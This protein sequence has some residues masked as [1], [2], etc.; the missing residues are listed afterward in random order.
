MFRNDKEEFKKARYARF[1]KNIVSDENLGVWA[2]FTFALNS[3]TEFIVV[4]DDDT[5]PGHRWIENCLNHSHLGLLGTIGLQYHDK[6]HYMN[7]V[8]FGW[9]NPNPEPVQV[10]IVGHSWFF[11]REWLSV[12]FSELQ[13]LNGFS[14]FGEDIHFSYTLQKYLSIPT[15]VPPHPHDDWNKWGSLNGWLGQDQHA[16]SMEPNAASKWDT[17]FH[18]YLKKG[19]KILNDQQ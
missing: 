18:Y 19:F 9:A 15:Y 8:R 7:H 12:Y 3:S 2:R 11:K 14:F 6:N 5:I 16:L 1:C 17:P 10:D 13:P 4:F